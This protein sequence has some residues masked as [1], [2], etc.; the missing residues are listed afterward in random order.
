MRLDRYL[1]NMGCGSRREVRELIKH[2]QVQVNQEIKRQASYHVQP[3]DTVMCSGRRV[4]YQSFSYYLLNK[5]AGILT[6]TKDPHAQTVLDLLP[7][8]LPHYTDLAPIGRLDRDTTG[9]LLITND[10]QL[11]HHLL[12]PRFHVAKVY[13][14]V[15]SGLVSTELVT[16][17]QQ[18]VKLEDFTTQPAQLSIKKLDPAKKQSL[19][20]LTIAEGKYHQ[21]KRMF[22]A[23][24][25]QVVTLKRIQFGALSLPVDLSVGDYQKLS[26]QELAQL[27][28]K[29]TP[30]STEE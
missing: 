22:K 26:D 24:G 13:E 21:V 9:L 14:A 20:R 18:G 6:A 3:K 17:F 4:N 30:A 10:G 29:Q 15:V 7:K 23:F 5:P 2:G 19:V 12:Q 25:H 16:I 1:A 8:N 11:T 28:L 27:K